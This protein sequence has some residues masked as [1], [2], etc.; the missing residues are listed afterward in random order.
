ML[1]RLLEIPG[2][3]PSAHRNV[4]LRK[5]LYVGNEE[6]IALL[7][8]HE[9]LDLGVPGSMAAIVEVI[10]RAPTPALALAV[11]RHPS[12]PQSESEGLLRRAAL[13]ATIYNSRDIASALTE[14]AAASPALQ[15]T[16]ALQAAIWKGDEAAALAL[17]SGGLADPT[18]DDCEALVLACA[19]DC[20]PV[21]DALLALP[22]VDPM[23]QGG[24]ALLRAVGGGHLSATQRLLACPRADP[25]ANDN[26][27][28]RHVIN[29]WGAEPIQAALM[30]DPRVAS[31]AA[32]MGGEAGMRQWEREGG[33]EREQDY[34]YSGDE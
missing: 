15:A 24:Q 33:G 5:A 10:C 20:T 34:V 16:M 8:S 26:A 13:Q 9:R 1:R 11:L 18:A 30:A 23:A 28:Y 19:Q 27:A 2:V 14:A 6:I 21:I 7:L 32:R 29:Q 12:L 17:L 31:V 25:S 3:S 22:A 4:A